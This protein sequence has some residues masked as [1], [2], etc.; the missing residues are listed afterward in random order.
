MEIIMKLLD[1]LGWITI[2]FFAAL[3]L[4]TIVTLLRTQPNVIQV[5]QKQ[6]SNFASE[7]KT[8]QK[9]YFKKNTTRE[10]EQAEFGIS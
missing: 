4:W 8:K 1:I 10:N 9:E 3:I 6:L 5:A 7:L 2:V